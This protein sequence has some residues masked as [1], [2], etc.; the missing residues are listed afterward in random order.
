MYGYHWYQHNEIHW[1]TLAADQRHLL[2][3]CVQGGWLVEKDKWTHNDKPNERRFHRA[4]RLAANRFDTRGLLNREPSD[5]RP[6]DE[7]ENLGEGDSDKDFSI[8]EADLTDE[9]DVTYDE[10]SAASQKVQDNIASLSEN[11]QVCRPRFQHVV[12][13]SLEW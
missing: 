11:F 2:L 9:W 8:S 1:T 10:A 6:H 12:F 3:Q 13:D 5:D 7:V 4:Y